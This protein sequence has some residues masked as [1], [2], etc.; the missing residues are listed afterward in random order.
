MAKVIDNKT[1][2][3]FIYNKGRPIKPHLK[4]IFQ[5]VLRYHDADIEYDRHL[6]TNR[7]LTSRD[8]DERREWRDSHLTDIKTR[9][10][11][12][13]KASGKYNDDD[14]EADYQYLPYF[15]KIKE[16]EDFYEF[17]FRKEKYYV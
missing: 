7:Y 3:R 2:L 5:E 8:L 12:L 16:Y 10:L 17:M 14:F 15:K 9:I 11:G 6:R 13:L 1:K 4:N